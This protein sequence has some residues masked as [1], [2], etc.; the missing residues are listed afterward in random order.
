MQQPTIDL[1][2]DSNRLDN[3]NGVDWMVGWMV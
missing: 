3:F 1:C 2:M